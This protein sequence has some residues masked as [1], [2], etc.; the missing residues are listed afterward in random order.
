MAKVKVKLNSQGV[1]E[2]LKSDE[3]LAACEER[4][5]QVSDKAGDGFGVNTRKGKKRA[6][7]QV[8]AETKDAL[9]KC[10]RE[11]TLLKSL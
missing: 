2:L 11:N 3:I 1:A 8:K 4:A 6:I 10:F 7:A 5:N 9:F